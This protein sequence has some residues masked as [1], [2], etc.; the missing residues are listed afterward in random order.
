MRIC[1]DNANFCFVAKIKFTNEKLK[2]LADYEYFEFAN[3]T[4][5]LF[6]AYHPNDTI[7]IGKTKNILGEPALYAKNKKTGGK[8]MEQIVDKSLGRYGNI[9]AFYRLLMKLLDYYNWG[10]NDFWQ[11]DANGRPH[12]RPKKILG[13]KELSPLQ[14]SVFI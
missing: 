1:Y 12:E 6:E 10:H 4:L 7:L 11:T 5:N 3:T 2:E 9:P 13:S 8:M 14:H